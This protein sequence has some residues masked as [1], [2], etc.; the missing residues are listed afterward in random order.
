MRAPPSGPCEQDWIATGLSLN[1]CSFMRE[2]QSMAFFKPPGIDQ[3]YSG[4]TN[5]HAVGG[6]DRGG[7]ASRRRGKPDAF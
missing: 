3:L 6:A 4:V 5:E 2:T 7:E 1:G